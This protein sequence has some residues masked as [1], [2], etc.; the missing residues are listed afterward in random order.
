M[1]L[2][3]VGMAPRSRKGLL[4]DILNFLRLGTLLQGHPDRML[5]LHHAHDALVSLPEPVILISLY[6]IVAHAHS[7]ADHAVLDTA[8]I[9]QAADAQCKTVFFS[10]SHT[11]IFR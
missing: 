6:T 7:H 1:A 2:R 10:V 3:M 11:E 9:V 8:A 5:L 4:Q